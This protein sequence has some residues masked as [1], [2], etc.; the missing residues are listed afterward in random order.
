MPQKVR[1]PRYYARHAGNGFM[2]EKYSRRPKSR[3]KWWR[4]T[5]SGLRRL[6]D[7]ELE[8]Y[9]RLL[10]KAMG[11]PQENIDLAAVPPASE[12]KQ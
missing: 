3:L 8:Q 2:P 6:S 10:T 12:T 7:E 11:L 5:K 9:E 1:R 4:G